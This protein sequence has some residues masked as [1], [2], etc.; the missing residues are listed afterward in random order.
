MTGSSCKMHNV[1][2]TTSDESYDCRASALNSLDVLK[3]NT[4]QYFIQQCNANTINTAIS[5]KIANFKT[6][7][8]TKK[9][10]TK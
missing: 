6:R 5:K 3:S 7:I 10:T 8:V 1:S 9:D 4:T 2:D